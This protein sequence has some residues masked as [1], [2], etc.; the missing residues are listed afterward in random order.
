ML[1][2]IKS[3]LK[4]PVKNAFQKYDIIVIVI[5]LKTSFLEKDGDNTDI[6][7]YTIVCIGVSTPLLPCLKLPLFLAKRK[8]PLKSANCSSL[9]F[10][11]N[12]PLY[13]GFS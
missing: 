8:S 1:P 2:S 12:P 3:N 4:L 6:K 10:L 11:G 5:G 13:I 9:P 7:N